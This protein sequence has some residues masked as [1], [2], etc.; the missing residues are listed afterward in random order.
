MRG[1][2]TRPTGCSWCTWH[3]VWTQGAGRCPAAASSGVSTPD[4]AVLR[5]LEEETGISEVRQVQVAAI[6]THTYAR[7]AQRPYPPFHHIG[8]VYEVTPGTS[9]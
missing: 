7:T 1:A 2:A 5:E 3:A 4:A 6:Y 8:I 9:I